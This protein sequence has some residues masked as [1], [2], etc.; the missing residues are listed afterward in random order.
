MILCLERHK[1]NH[2]D[3]VIIANVGAMVQ[4]VS[5]KGENTVAVIN[6]CSGRLWTVVATKLRRLKVV[7]MEREMHFDT[8]KPVLG[9]YAH[10]R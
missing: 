3:V 9:L 1:G 8:L 2:V 10:S 4:G 5:Q 7:V 6:A